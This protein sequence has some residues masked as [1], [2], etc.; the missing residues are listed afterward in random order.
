MPAIVVNHTEIKSVLG[1]ILGVGLLTYRIYRQRHHFRSLARRS[2]KELLAYAVV[3]CVI[4]A[5]LTAG[6]WAWTEF[7]VDHTVRVP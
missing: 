1:S 4:I 7:R 5:V 6:A 2:W 3:S